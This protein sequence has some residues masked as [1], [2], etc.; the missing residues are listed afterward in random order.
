VE[1]KLTRISSVTA[2][3]EESAQALIRQP[4]GWLNC[5]FDEETR[6]AWLAK[7][8]GKQHHRG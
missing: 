5:S 6:E 1:K 4:S 8:V 7:S 3:E 2:S